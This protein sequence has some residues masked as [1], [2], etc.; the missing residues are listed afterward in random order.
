MTVH[1]QQPGPTA[2][3]AGASRGL[4]LALARELGLRGHRV[5]ITA[6]SAPE[7]ER[8]A[9]VLNADGITVWTRTHDV[10]DVA[11]TTDL[12]AD[13]EAKYGP[14][15]ILVVVA[16][17]LQ[18]G[19][20]PDNASE[21]AEPL[22]TMLGGP[23]NVVHAALPGMR[24]RGRGRIGVVTSIGGLVPVPHL[25]PYSTAKF[26][27]VGFAQGLS[28]EL[29]G[30]GISVS[31]IIPGLMRTGGHWNAEYHGRPHREYV[32]FTLMASLP[33]VSIEASRAARIIVDGVA[34]GKRRIIFTPMAR[35]AARLYGLA[36]EPVT[37]TLGVMGRYLLPRSGDEELPGRQAAGRIR[38]RIFDQATLLG[39]RAVRRWNQ[40]NDPSSGG[41]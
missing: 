20:L 31:T 3:V 27:A 37:W 38:S 29:Q 34:R 41:Q 1:G 32:W 35:V 21:Y 10:S 26:G 2:L 28:Q 5:V 18:V 8:A 13:V 12:F 11:G 24:A 33:V 17:M 14:I 39:R 9:Q 25:V 36:P 30:T 6:R 23:I 7:L 19:P 40:T 16:G 4:G 15:E 22:Q